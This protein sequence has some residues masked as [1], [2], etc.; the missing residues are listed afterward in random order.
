MTV[1]LTAAPADPAPTRR[2]RRPAPRRG[3]GPT[4]AMGLAFVGPYVV[5]MLA[6]G[7]IPA[8]YAVALAFSRADGGFAG[9]DNFVRVITDFRFLP[10]VQHVAV[11]LVLWLVMLTV[12]VVVLALVLH[13]VTT[14]WVS[15]AL[16]LLYYLPGALA[17]ASAVLLWLFVLNPDAGPAGPLLKAMGFETFAQTIQ[18]G[19]LSLVFAVIAFWTGA[20][21]WV[22]VMYGALNNIPTEVMEAA[23]I[24]GANPVQIALRIQLPLLRKWIAYMAVLA[25]AAGTQLFVEPTLLSQASTGVVPNDYSVNQLAYQ[26]AFNLSDFNGAAAIAVLLL[27]VSVAL[28]AVFVLRGGLFDTEEP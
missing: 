12:L 3:P 6:F 2:R 24:D 16:R 7:I 11:Y 23:R 28:S 25:L 1:E 17:G 15:R 8:V 27:V 22:I 21:Q 5:L 19:N 26:Y 20:G 14:R 4:R 13:A 18:P 10:A 9:L